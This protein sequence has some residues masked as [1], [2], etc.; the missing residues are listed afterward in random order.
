MKQF[1]TFAANS[2]IHSSYHSPK[3]N[4]HT[5][6]F[7]SNAESREHEQQKTA[8]FIKGSMPKIPNAEM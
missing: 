6:R 7:P 1:S 5:I 8:H 2:P 3:A 4:S